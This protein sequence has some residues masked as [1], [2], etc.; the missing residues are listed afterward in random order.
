MEGQ[1]PSK[2]TECLVEQ[3]RY[4]P[5][6]QKMGVW[7]VNRVKLKN[8]V[9]AAV[10]LVSCLFFLVKAKEAAAMTSNYALSAPTVQ[11][12]SVVSLGQ[13]YISE[14][15]YPNSLKAGDTLSISFPT[16]VQLQKIQIQE[17]AASSSAANI[18]IT[19]DK[20]KKQFT[21][22][23]SPCQDLVGNFTL[24]RPRHN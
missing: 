7:V 21:I 19:L 8:G 23:G 1:G 15:S 12:D 4:Y 20:V 6:E 5:E 22:T 11:A 17:T 10:L 3:L 13:L 18:T 16:T 24:K 9:I 14:A 2:N